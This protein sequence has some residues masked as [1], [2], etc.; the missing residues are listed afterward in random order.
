MNFAFTFCFFRKLNVVSFRSVSRAFL[1][2]LD[3]LCCLADGLF[4][5]TCVLL[6][7]VLKLITSVVSSVRLSGLFFFLS[8]FAVHRLHKPNMSMMFRMVDMM[9]FVYCIRNPR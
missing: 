2:F 6:G 9:R 5:K 3:I 1:I 4:S 8:S 7:G